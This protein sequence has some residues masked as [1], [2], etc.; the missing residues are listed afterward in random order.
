MN[1]LN[2]ILLSLCLV[3]CHFSLAAN[4][5]VHENDTTRIDS[6]LV[7]Y[8]YETLENKQLGNINNWDTTIFSAS[9][10]DPTNQLF[11]FYQELS[12]SGHA[13]KKLDFPFPTSIGFNDYL[14]S[15][16][17]FIFT[18]KKI[19]YPIVYQPF[20]QINYMMG[21]KKEQHLNAIF[22][23]EFLPRFFITINFN[24]DY[25]P[26]VYQRS[27]AQDY[28]FIINFR[29]NTKD[30]KY[31][32]NGYFFSN[33]IDVYE[34][35]GITHDSIFINSIRDDDN[36]T[37]VNL[38]KASNKIKVQ[39][40]GINQY[41]VLGYTDEDRDKKIGFGRI[42]YSFDYQSNKYA[43]KD[44]DPSSSFYDAFDTLIDKSLTYDSISFYTIKNC[45]S[46]N[47]LSFKK[48]NNDIPFYLSAGLEHNYTYHPGYIDILTG[49]KFNIK[50]YQNIRAKGGIIINLFKSTRITGN[51][52]II[53]NDYQAGDL[54]LY[55]QWKQFLG[56]YKRN[57]GALVFDANISRQ[58][59]DWF[60]SYYYSNSF[61]WD[62]DFTPSTYIKV[63]GAYET[64][65]FSIGLKQMTIDH[66]IYFAENAKPTQHG[67]S[68]YVTSFFGKLKFNFKYFELSGI[69]SFQK[70]DNENVIHLPFFY[71]KMK[72]AWNITLVKG[73]SIMQ[74]SVL[75][76]YFTE[77][78]ADAYMP[79]HRT[80]YLQND[81]KVGNYPFVDFYLTFKLKRSNIFLGYT[82]LYSFSGEKGYFTTPHYPMRDSRFI[83]GLR[84]RLYK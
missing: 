66:Y 11:E 50:R 77:Y 44:T 51:G 82:N 61:R 14:D 63:T 4:S 36:V 35:G 10:Y 6:T 18:K 83:F 17:K 39:G 25:A 30:E 23:R 31:G 22:C 40:F 74:P 56:T 65:W 71:T 68:L 67:G 52:E 2:K 46:I 62:N 72:M 45:V 33:N 78:Y 19:I 20:T 60:E 80:F 1:F 28:N 8:F 21:G 42:C 43:Y 48:Y 76:S 13:H 12:N 58:S 47:T 69:A 53:L 32:I 26:S 79:V 49:E 15:Y 75:V 38:M 64:P 7:R 59:P 37:P 70:T 3:L 57:I 54:M 16:D 29:W 9:F 5:F 84:W 24:I 73:I 27:L 55:G 41:F 34:N 81:V